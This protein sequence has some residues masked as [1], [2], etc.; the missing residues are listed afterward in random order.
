M[1]SAQCSHVDQIEV[2]EPHTEEGCEDCLAMGGRW[3]HLRLCLSCGHVGCCDSSPNRHA[4]KHAASDQHPIVKSFEPGEEWRWCY[5]D[6][7]VV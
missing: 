2:V 4:S 5:V 7:V 6:E 1:A 3:V